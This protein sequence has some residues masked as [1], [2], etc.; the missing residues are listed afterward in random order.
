MEYTPLMKD[1]FDMSFKYKKQTFRCYSEDKLKKVS[2]DKNYRIIG[3]AR[4]TSKDS[5]DV[6]ILGD[7]SMPVF[8]TE[9][10]SVMYKSIG[11]IPVND[12]DQYIAVQE[13]RTPFLLIFS[14]TIVMTAGICISLLKPQIPVTPPANDPAPTF[15]PLPPVDTN[16]EDYIDDTPSE[17]STDKESL[18][19]GGSVKISCKPNAFV[20]LSTGEV[21]MEYQNPESSTH[22]AMIDLYV[23]SGDEEYLIASSGRIPA[24]KQ[25]KTM[26]FTADKSLFSSEGK[27]NAEYKVY[28]YDSE[29]GERALTEATIDDITLTVKNG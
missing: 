29:T 26:Q 24:G 11:Y 1:D 22:D 21:A 6:I 2:Y 25:L 8:N 19:G 3:L 17:D 23:V 5:D 13:S 9:E 10:S 15:N 28:Y 12:G 27:Y 20:E 14:S 4:K 16:I 18:K 7:K